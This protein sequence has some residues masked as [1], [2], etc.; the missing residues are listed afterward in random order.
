MLLTL[1]AGSG[2]ILK[3][4]RNA[5]LLNNEAWTN[6]RMPE[7]KNEIWTAAGINPVTA[8]VMV[9]RATCIIFI[10]RGDAVVEAVS[11]PFC[12][13]VRPVRSF[14]NSQNLDLGKCNIPSGPSEEPMQ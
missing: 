13:V 10:A 1:L 5:G 6:D 12:E 14:T 11:P 2:Y 7:T 8:S 3:N 9:G 4:E